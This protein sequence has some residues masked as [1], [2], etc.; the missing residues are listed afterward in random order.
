MFN[1]TTT[2]TVDLSITGLHF[3]KSTVPWPC[4]RLNDEISLST[5]CQ[6]FV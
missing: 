5:D 6:G 4:C 2:T 3:V 1:Q